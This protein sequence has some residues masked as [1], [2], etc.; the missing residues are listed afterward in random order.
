MEFVQP[1]VDWYA[2]APIERTT[3]S[4]AVANTIVQKT[5]WKGDDDVLAFLGDIV[6]TIVFRRK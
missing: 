3:L 5:P 1:V 4:L 6:K 2:E